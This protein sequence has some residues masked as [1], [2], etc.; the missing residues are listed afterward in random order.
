MKNQR[1]KMGL[2]KDQKR[3]KKVLKLCFVGLGNPG[4]K[5]NNTR[6]NIG[7]DWLLKLC[8]SESVKLLNKTKFEADLV[9]SESKEILYVVPNNYVNNSGRTISKLV[10]NLNL[11][12][13]KII[14]LHDDLDLNPGQVRLKEGGGHGG[15]NGLRDIFEKTGSKDFMRI[16][17]G[18]GHPGNKNQVSD[19]VLNKF[20]PTDKLY[21]NNSYDLFLSNFDSICNQEFSAAQKA[22]HTE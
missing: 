10:K 9:Y 12:E 18:V 17:I 4:S 16:R 7:K 13:S 6:H 21:I 22:M 20:H 8:E 15:H 14:I 2:A 5:Y 3:A 19:W 11:S 1:L